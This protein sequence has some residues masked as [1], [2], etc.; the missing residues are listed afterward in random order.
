MADCK[1]CGGLGCRVT[2]G[3]QFAR[4]EVCECKRDCKEC[5]GGGLVVEN[6][7]GYRYASPC[8]VCAPALNNVKKYNN[9]KIPVAMISA[10]LKSGG[11]SGSIANAVGYMQKFISKYPHEK[12]FV[13][14]GSAGRGKTSF[15]TAVLA[16]LTLKNG[17]E[18]LFFD[19]NDLILQLKGREEGVSEI[20]VLAPC[21]ETEVLVL[22]SV[23]MDSRPLTEWEKTVLENIIS[24]RY[25]ANKKIIL[26]TKHGK[27]DLETEIGSQAF[28]KINTMCEFAGL[29]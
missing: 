4:A 11:G 23:G 27:S 1:K 20:A 13:L 18:G 29:D 24:K 28:S 8:P 5:G 10:S 21:F 19:F 17:I 6:K 2:R 25:R 14:S 26:T 3:K 9:A 12:G 22:D 16:D 15:A 7:E